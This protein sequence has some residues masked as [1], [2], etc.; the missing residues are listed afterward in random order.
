MQAIAICLDLAQ[1]AASDCVP[2]EHLPV[3]WLW[4]P[5]LS[6]TAKPHRARAE[7]LCKQRLT[8]VA[9]VNQA[10]A[11]FGARPGTAANVELDGEHCQSF[12]VETGADRKVFNHPRNETGGTAGGWLV[13]VALH[14]A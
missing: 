5:S 14:S 4:A 13:R 8:T 7:Q 6:A 9:C 1:Q 3:R 12:V 2:W 10:K 11:S